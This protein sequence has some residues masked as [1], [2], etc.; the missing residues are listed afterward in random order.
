MTD[1]PE[2]SAARGDRTMSRRRLLST[3]GGLLAGGATLGVVGG[4]TGA[5]EKE[6]RGWRLSGGRQERSQR[7]NFVFIMLDDAGLG[8][9]DPRRGPIDTPHVDRLARE[10]MTFTQMYCGSSVCSPSRA[11]LLTGRYPVRVGIPDVLR[12]G[13]D[14]GISRWERTLAELLHDRGYATGIFGKWHLGEKREFNPVHHGFDEFIGLLHSTD[15]DPVKLYDGT[16]VLQDKVDQRYLTRRLTDEAMTFIE[17]QHGR[18]K[19]FFTYI[20][21]T[22]PHIP[23]HVQPGFEG[24]S[25]AGKYGDVVES[26]DF[27]IGRVLDK[28][29]QLGL[30]ETTVVV[31]TSDNGPWFQG[32][33]GG[34][35]GRKTET[36]EGGIRAPFYIRWPGRIPE[37]SHSDTI[38]SFL[39]ILPTFCGLAGAERPNDR[40]M[41]GIDLR[42]A[43]HGDDMPARPPL[44]HFESTH[45]S[46]VRYGPWK[47]NI[48]QK[49]DQHAK[50]LLQLF[51]INDDPAEQYDQ[52]PTH[53]A[54]KH[55]LLRMAQRIHNDLDPGRRTQEQTVRPPGPDRLPHTA[56]GGVRD[57]V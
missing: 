23:L 24:T 25:S 46:A 3:G 11:A 8:D 7:P 14:R 33:T 55:K 37:A 53:P 4:T 16:K 48:P 44:A 22:A 27:H 18:D 51:N 13:S 26:V 35:R 6:G 17:S 52:G 30:A 40:P 39:D 2:G 41:D 49:E 38:A 57:R 20:P 56:S 54:T 32:S 45:L 5:A 21:Y 29:D 47:L 9:L 15:Q 34:L 12:P 19:P 36:Y 28:L 42:P 10:G 1:E 50:Q 31:V 43:L